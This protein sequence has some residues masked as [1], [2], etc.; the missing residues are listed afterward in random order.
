MVVRHPQPA[1]KLTAGAGKILRF[2]R[3]QELLRLDKIVRTEIILQVLQKSATEVE[4]FS[5]CNYR[6]EIWLKTLVPYF[7]APEAVIG[8][9]ILGRRAVCFEIMVFPIRERL[10]GILH[11]MEEDIALEPLETAG[12]AGPRVVIETDGSR[13]YQVAEYPIEMLL[14]A[15]RQERA[16]VIVV[17]VRAVEEMICSDFLP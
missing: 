9:G 17:A 3:F 5:L 12:A 2:C 1:H 10:G 15:D 14:A 7:F 13:F 11:G 16:D 6:I 8:F 4:P